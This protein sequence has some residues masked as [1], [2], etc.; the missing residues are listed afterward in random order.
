MTGTRSEGT[1]SGREGGWVGSCGGGV[2]QDGTL[3]QA[4]R[5][6]IMREGGGAASGSDEYAFWITGGYPREG[7][8]VV[9]RSVR[10]SS[11]L[12]APNRIVTSTNE[13]KS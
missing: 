9:C 7:G 5:L 10:F 3:Y 1:G 12:F 13:T 11:S 4:D 8:R 6:E 2:W